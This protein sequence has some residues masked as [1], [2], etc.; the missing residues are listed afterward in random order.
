MSRVGLGF[1]CEDQNNPS[2]PE[3]EP[4]RSSVS[5]TKFKENF[6]GPISSSF[7]IQQTEI[8]LNIHSGLSL[9]NGILEGKLKERTRTSAETHFLTFKHASAMGYEQHLSRTYLLQ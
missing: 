3:L 8:I 7:I 4:I 5:P 6:A 9:F 2:T 1:E